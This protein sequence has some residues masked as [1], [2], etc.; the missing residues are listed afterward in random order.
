MTLPTRDG[1]FDVDV[2]SIRMLE[3][4]ESFGTRIHMRSGETLLVD[5]SVAQIEFACMIN[6]K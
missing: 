5:L 3:D 6:T 2:A 4:V 1:F